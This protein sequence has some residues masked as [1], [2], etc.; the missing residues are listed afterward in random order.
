MKKTEIK[1]K[2]ETDTSQLD[3]AIKKAE[4]LRNI[5]EEAMQLASSMANMDLELEINAVFNDTA[6]E[7]ARITTE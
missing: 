2:I 4:R 1:M 3:I 6:T 5:M 7:L